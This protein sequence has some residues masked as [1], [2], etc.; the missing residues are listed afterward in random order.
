MAKSMLSGN[1]GSITVTQGGSDILVDLYPAE[2]TLQWTQDTFE[3]LPFSP[4]NNMPTIGKGATR[5]T[6]T[7]SGFLG[8]NSTDL[9]M[10][11]ANAIHDATTKSDIVLNVDGSYP[12]TCSNAIVDSFNVTTR[13][14]DFASFTMSFTCT[15]DVDITHS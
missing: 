4:T 14:A 6:G 5:I 10:Q 9:A 1:G 15:E 11:A 13:Q 3:A 2:W 12:W 8:Y 7:A